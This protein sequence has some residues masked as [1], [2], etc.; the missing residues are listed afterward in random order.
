MGKAGEPI[1]SAAELAAADRWQYEQAFATWKRF[2]R[3]EGHTVP[4]KEIERI[5]RAGSG[6]T[7]LKDA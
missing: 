7:K 3:G 5:F 4:R 1:E 6:P 2:R